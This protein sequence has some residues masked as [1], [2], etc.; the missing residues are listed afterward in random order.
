[1]FVDA[2]VSKLRALQVGT[3]VMSIATT[4][5]TSYRLPHASG[6]TEQVAPIAVHSP[7]QP[8]LMFQVRDNRGNGD[9]ARRAA[10]FSPDF[11]SRFWVAR[12]K[13]GTQNRDGAQG[14]LRLS[15]A[16]TPVAPVVPHLEHKIVLGT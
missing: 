7:L 6:Q 5:F 4:A 16:L 11:V 12:G 14:I 3:A 2:E 10:A 9:R 13:I 1:V 15:G 8:C